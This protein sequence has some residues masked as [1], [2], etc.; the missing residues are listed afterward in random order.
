MTDLSPPYTYTRTQTEALARHSLYFEA[1]FAHP[2]SEAHTRIVEVNL[3][4]PDALEPTLF[5]LYT[6]KAPEPLPHGCRLSVSPDRFFGLLANAKYLLLDALT[7]QCTAFFT[8][9]VEAGTHE[10]ACRTMHTRIS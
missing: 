8:R 9:L 4:C 7:E 1:L 3:P 5:H 6:G 2:F 10:G